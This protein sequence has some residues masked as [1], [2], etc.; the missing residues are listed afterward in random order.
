M[1]RAIKII[2]IEHQQINKNKVC[3]DINIKELSEIL[4]YTRFDGLNM[5]IKSNNMQKT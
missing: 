5:L 2:N 3:L 4:I 1:E